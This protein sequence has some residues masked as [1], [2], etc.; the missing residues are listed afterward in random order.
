MPPI[1][2][3]HMLINPSFWIEIFYALII[4]ITSLIIYFRTTEVAKLSQHKGIKYFRMTFLFFSISYL[5]RGILS[6]YKILVGRPRFGSLGLVGLPL[7]LIVYF[8]TMAFLYLIYSLIWKEFKHPDK[9]VIV[10]HFIAFLI[11]IFT[12]VLTRSGFAIFSL[13][14]LILLILAIILSVKKHNINKKKRKGLS[15]YYIIYIMFFASWIIN[16]MATFLFTNVSVLLGGFIYIISI[17]LL[18]MVMIKI[19]KIT[20]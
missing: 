2:P 18:I 11:A 20:K 5:L 12:F 16:N 14:Q 9:I 13:I 10:L 15:Q 1:P 8:S 4:I 17:L 6:L 7:F 3:P 19:I